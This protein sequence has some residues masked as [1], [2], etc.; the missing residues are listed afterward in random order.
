MAANFVKNGKLPTFVAV[1]FRNEMGYRYL[2]V[3]VNSANDASI[4]CKNFVKFCPATPELTELIC[5]R[6]VDTAKT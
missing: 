6:L 4:S 2:N 3:H 1:A 5:E